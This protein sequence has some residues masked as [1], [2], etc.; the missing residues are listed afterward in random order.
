MGKSW[1]IETLKRK[2]KENIR[3]EDIPLRDRIYREEAMRHPEASVEKQTAFGFCRFLEEKPILIQ[4]EDLLAGFAFH[5]SYNST[6][7]ADGPEDFDPAIKSVFHMDMDREIRETAD[8][9][10]LKDTDPLLEKLH[11]FREGMDAWLYKHWHSGHFLAGYDRLVEKGFGTIFSDAEAAKEKHPENRDTLE[12]FQMTAK[13]CT[14]YILRYRDLAQKLA[15]DS[16]DGDTAFRMRRIQKS[17]ERIAQGRPQTFFDALQLTWFAHELA[18]CESYPASVSIGRFDS[19]LYPFYHADREAGRITEEETLELIEAFWIKCSTNTKGYQ[20]LA[21]GGTDSE[22]KCMANDLTCL[23]MQASRELKFDQPSLTFRWTQDLPDRVWEEILSLIRTGMGFPALFGESCC[24]QAKAKAGIRPE[25]LH[26][27]AFV[28]CVELTIPGK[29]YVLTEAAR[30]NLPK[31][32]ELMLHQGIDPVSGKQFPLRQKKTAEEID[33]IDR[34]DQFFSWYLQEM[35]YW[36]GL[37]ADAVC[38]FDRMYGEKYPLPFLSILMEG[39]VESGK[40]VSSGGA[41]YNGTAFN[42]CGIATVT[43][44]LTAIR[45]LVFEQK[46]LPLSAYVKAMD[47]NY[48]GYEILR[49]QAEKKCPKFGNDNDRADQIAVEIMERFCKAVEQRETPRGGRFRPGFYTVEDHAIMGSYTGAT[50]DGRKKGE[51]LSN[52]F[53]A[54][55]GKDISGPTALINTVRKFDLSRAGNGMV[56]DL[57]FTPTFLDGETGQQALRQ[58][59]DTY[60]SRGGMEVQISVVSGETLRRAQER[61]EE[62]QDLVVRVSGFSAYFTSL[63]KVTQDEIIRRTEVAR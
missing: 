19:Y 41:V 52:S 42:Q 51:A 48:E 22:G 10:G 14:S 15:D 55:Q 27:Y 37:G 59:L 39:C 16:G 43:D 7:P 50:P 46:K 35:E 3:R 45:Q 1:R 40:D 2:R 47:A 8:V 33:Q 13:A 57:K 20:N 44:S 11:I 12:A 49:K 60:F 31:I 34:F 61:P 53:A 4:K 28:G 25:D 21:L 58:L 30:L 18:L 29:E 36:I 6:F 56:L 63:R 24:R 9:L 62:Y 23:C 54:S 32:L 17:C 38:A 26:R 5:Y